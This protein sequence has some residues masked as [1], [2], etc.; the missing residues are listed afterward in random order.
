MPKITIRYVYRIPNHGE[1]NLE[2]APQDTLYR[3]SH[4]FPS[5][6]VSDPSMV[7][8]GTPLLLHLSTS[9]QVTEGKVLDPEKAEYCD[10]WRWHTFYTVM[11]H[12]DCPHI[13]NFLLIPP[14]GAALD[15]YRK[16]LL[17][18]GKF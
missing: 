3:P 12:S 10:S 14:L 15:E 6:I 1:G 8:R 18:V 17:W 9:R 4:E 5:L 13:R 11:Q 7:F 16:V 2:D